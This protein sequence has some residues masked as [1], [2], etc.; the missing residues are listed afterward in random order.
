MLIYGCGC[1]LYNIEDCLEEVVISEATFNEPRQTTL[2]CPSC[3]TDFEDMLTYVDLEIVEL[4]N[5]G[6]I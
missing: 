1:G 4:L 2:V 3:G 5:S 6:E